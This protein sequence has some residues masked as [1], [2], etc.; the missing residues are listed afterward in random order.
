MLLTDVQDL[1]CF[2]LGLQRYSF[3][4]EL[5]VVFALG[6]AHTE[7]VHGH[8]PQTLVAEQA[9]AVLQQEELRQL[10]AISESK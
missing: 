7:V 5:Q 6:R 1:D 2:S 9:H 10:C 3:Q 4:T 8:L